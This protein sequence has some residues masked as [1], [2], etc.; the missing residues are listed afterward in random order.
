[1]HDL[2][3][4]TKGDNG[5]SK[6]LGGA[7]KVKGDNGKDMMEVEVPTAKED[8]DSMWAASRNALRQKPAEVKESRDA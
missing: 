2:G 4:G 5:S 1:L 6:D 8:I 3:W 7:K